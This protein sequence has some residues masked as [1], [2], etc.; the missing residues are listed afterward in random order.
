MILGLLFRRVGVDIHVR[1]HYVPVGRIP[2]I[3][4]VLFALSL[5]GGAIWL[6]L[7]TVSG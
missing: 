4:L 6:V 3:V 5:M 7:K 2:V 1:N